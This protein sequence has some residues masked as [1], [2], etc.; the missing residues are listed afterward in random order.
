M[1]QMHKSYFFSDRTTRARTMEAT[2]IM[3]I[4]ITLWETTAELDDT[5]NTEVV[6]LVLKITNTAILVA[7]MVSMGCTIDLKEFKETVIKYE[8][9]SA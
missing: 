7:L 2:S 8:M 4:N 5:P 3:T 6:K 9:I 1:A